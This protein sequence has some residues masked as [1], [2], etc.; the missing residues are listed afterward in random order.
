MESFTNLVCT[1][2]FLKYK[3]LEN[4]QLCGIRDAGATIEAHCPNRQAVLVLIHAISLL[5]SQVDSEFFR[6]VEDR[7]VLAFF[8]KLSAKG[9]CHNYSFHLELC[10]ALT[11]Q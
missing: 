4:F 5:F 10:S 7:S 8:L 6:S 1:T 3:S 9:S 11:S 2:K